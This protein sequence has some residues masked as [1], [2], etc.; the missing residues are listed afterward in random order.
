MWIGLASIV[1][2][3][4]GLTSAY[5]VRH[6]AGNWEYFKLPGIFGISTLVI[7]LSSASLYLAYRA[8]KENDKR[9]YTQMLGATLGLGALFTILQYVGWKELTSY[10]VLLNGN[11]SGSFLYVI[12][13]LH[14]LH[15]VGGLLFLTI[16]LFKSLKPRD[17]V[18]QLL[19]DINPDKTLGIEILSYYWHFVGILWLYLYLFFRYFFVAASHY[20]KNKFAI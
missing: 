13:G 17:A 16:F 2:M 14:A 4:S 1:M 15:V 18:G 11:P 7:L 19:Y 8:A 12:S 10:G 9:K 20:L 6:A 5:I 3:F